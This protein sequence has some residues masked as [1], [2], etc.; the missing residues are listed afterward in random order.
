MVPLLGVGG[1]GTVVV[2]VVV[3]VVVIV[4]LHCIG[5]RFLVPRGS[6]LDVRVGSG[7]E[8]R[9]RAADATTRVASE[10][11]PSLGRFARTR[12][13]AAAAAMSKCL[14]RCLAWPLTAPRRLR[15]R[16]PPPPPLRLAS[17]PVKT[18]LGVRVRGREHDFAPSHVNALL[19]ALQT[20]SRKRRT[21]FYAEVRSRGKKSIAC[22]HNLRVTVSACPARRRCVA[23]LAEASTAPLARL[24]ATPDEFHLLVQVRAA[25]PCLRLR[26]I[27]GM[28]F[29]WSRRQS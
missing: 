22:Y 27:V 20:T 25:A 28:C 8:T 7:V 11:S 1:G 3:V 14:D 4:A 2:V 12:R 19:R 21:A 24:F 16:P 15:H 13:R 6:F 29:F 26:I 10:P 18:R 9:R 23:A 5:G 17:S